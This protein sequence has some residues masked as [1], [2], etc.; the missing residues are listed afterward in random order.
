[1]FE[2]ERA[3]FCPCEEVFSLKCWGWKEVKGEKGW[4][5]EDKKN[6]LWP[7]DGQS[8]VY[9]ST[10]FCLYLSV[11]KH[12]RALLFPVYCHSHSHL[13]A[14]PLWCLCVGCCGSVSVYPGAACCSNSDRSDLG[15]PPHGPS[16]CVV[17]AVSTLWGS[18]VHPPLSYLQDFCPANGGM[19]AVFV[20]YMQGHVQAHTL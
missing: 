13:T 2:R 18:S 4:K 16:G 10:F 1:M 8:K 9:D 19:R 7:I 20:A 5:I 14:D 6:I 17:T 3:A 12:L 11:I 15:L